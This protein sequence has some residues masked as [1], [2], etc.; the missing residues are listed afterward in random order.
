MNGEACD[1]FFLCRLDEGV[2]NAEA[3]HFGFEVVVKHRLEGGHLWIHDDD[4]ACD[5][6]FAESDTLVSHGHGKIIY[7]VVLQCL[8][9]L[10]GSCTISVG[11]YHTYYFGFRSHKRAIVVEVCHHSVEIYLEYCLVHFLFKEFGDV[12]EPELSCAF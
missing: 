9:H 10:H 8:C 12:V 3:I 4:I 6:V 11:L 1:A 2:H 7:A 5:A